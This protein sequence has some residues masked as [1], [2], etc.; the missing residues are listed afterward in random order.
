MILTISITTLVIFETLGREGL[1]PEVIVHERRRTDR[2]GR[3]KYQSLCGGRLFIVHVS[4][5]VVEAQS[6]FNVSHLKQ[7]AW[8]GTSDID[9]S[10]SKQ[11]AITDKGPDTYLNDPKLASRQ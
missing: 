10:L 11:S 3:L 4:Y 9:Q 7:L 8:H 2:A 6:R 1:S 5:P